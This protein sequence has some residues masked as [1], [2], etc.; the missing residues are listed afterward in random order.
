MKIISAKQTK[1]VDKHSIQAEPI[2]SLNL[3]ERA[4]KACVESI[5]KQS[6][7]FTQF[8]VFCGK[9][10]NGG[11]GL[12]IARILASIHRKVQV[13]IIDYT[14][15]ESADFTANLKSLQKQNLV[16]IHFIT[17][18]TQIK[19]LIDKLQLNVNHVVIDS[20]LGTGINKKVEGLLAEVIEHINQLH[21]FVISIDMPSGLFC[22]EKPNHKTVIRANRTLT[23]QRPKL[24][25][26]FV[27]FYDYVGN[28]EVLDIGLD[29]AFI[30]FQPSNYF[31]V[32]AYEVGS[33]LIPRTKYANKGTFGHALL[34]AGSKGKIGA[35]ILSAKACLRAGAGLISAYIPACGYIPMQTALPEAMV[36]TDD[37]PNYLSACPDLGN[38]AA[39]GMGPGIGQEKETAQA[40]KL[41]IQQASNPLVL[42]ADA[43]NI[44]S[45]NKTWISFLPAN[46]ILTPHPKEFDRLT[47]THTS[48]FD[49]L[50]TC[51]EFTL[52]HNVIVVLKGAHTAVV[53]PN[54]QV[55]FN[56]S[57][58]AALAKGG[59]GDVLTGIILAFLA[60]GYTQEE[61]AVIAVYLHGLAAD[62]FVKNNNPE[63]MLAGD[64]IDM[65]K[66]IN[67]N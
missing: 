28:F 33:L 24:T 55:F 65:L 61:A 31:F 17:D 34:L 53:L 36:I 63:S 18:L 57:G 12:A 41:L 50:Q 58:N 59:S 14:E 49:R 13:F 20:L 56:S 66:E 16:T 54:Q 5:C 39:I 51:K 52:K 48:A 44:L 38:Y 27:D 19:S 15:K 37:N 35:A 64:L 40:L 7:S 62:N 60:K 67:F 3:M 29:E 21:Q 6:N 45:E 43:L 30:E 25:F 8:S 10:N 11:D 4:A 42:D 9:G 2:T 23:F 47:G 32:T 26:L 1:E 46:T 22:D